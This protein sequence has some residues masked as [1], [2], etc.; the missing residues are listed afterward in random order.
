MNDLLVKI[1][2]VQ[3]EESNELSKAYIRF[4]SIDPDMYDLFLPKEVKSKCISLKD[5]KH[6]LDKFSQ[7]KKAYCEIFKIQEAK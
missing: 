4:D 6:M 1:G 2:S 5:T 7:H 3:K